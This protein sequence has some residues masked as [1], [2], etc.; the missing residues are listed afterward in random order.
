MAQFGGNKNQPPWLGGG[1]AHGGHGHP[2]DAH[3]QPPAGLMGFGGPPHGGQGMHH[4]TGPP[5]F[6]P[7]QPHGPHPGMHPGPPGL[8]LVHG[9]HT[10]VSVTAA[11][12][13]QQVRR[14]QNFWYRVRVKLNLN[15]I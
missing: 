4:Q 8:S 6:A 5:V 2:G 9:P 3:M 12:A 14:H 15:G 10:P 7:A 1:G 11:I 13:G